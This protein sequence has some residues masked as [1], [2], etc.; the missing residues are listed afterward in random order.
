MPYIYGKCL[1]RREAIRSPAAQHAVAGGVKHEVRTA[2]QGSARRAIPEPG[3]LVVG[4]N[5][6]SALTQARERSGELQSVTKTDRC[7]QCLA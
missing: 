7:G 3:M 4:G 6:C 5:L 1:R 2:G